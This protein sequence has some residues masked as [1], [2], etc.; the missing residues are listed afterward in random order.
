METT[1]EILVCHNGSRRNKQ[2]L[3]SKQMPKNVDEAK[4]R[5][6][7]YL[8]LHDFYVLFTR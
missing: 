7:S 4:R 6:A 5:V 8:D 3:K 2:M 1:S